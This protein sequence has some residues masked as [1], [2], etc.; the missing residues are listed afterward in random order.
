MCSTCHLI[1]KEYNIRPL[2]SK[3][4]TEARC[5]CSEGASRE[6]GSCRDP[7]RVKTYICC[8]CSIELSQ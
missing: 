5:G 6:D 7:R 2:E 1:L 4:P 8:G 3:F